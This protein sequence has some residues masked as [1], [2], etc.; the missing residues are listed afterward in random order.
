MWTGILRGERF[1]DD[2]M[3]IDF[4]SSV[5]KRVDKC[6]QLGFGELLNGSTK[7]RFFDFSHKEQKN[8]KKPV[9]SGHLCEGQ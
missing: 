4:Y 8:K 3:L 1:L 6:F 5:E 9:S 7:R 2:E